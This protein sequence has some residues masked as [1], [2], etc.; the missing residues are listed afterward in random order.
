MKT[1]LDDRFAPI[2]SSIGYLRQDLDSA[3]DAL[4][5]WRRELFTVVESVQMMAALPECLPLLEPLTGGARPRELLVEVSGGW[6]AYFDCSLRGT[7]AVSTIGYLSERIGCQGLAVVTVPHTVH[8][9]GTGGQMGSVQFEMFG[10]LRTDFMNSVRSISASFD[11]NRWVFHA[12][13]TE[14]WFENSDAYKSRRIRDRF[15]AQMIDDYAKALEL[16]VFDPA[17]YGPR[18][19]LVS[20]NQ[21]VPPS[22]S[23]MSLE[24]V[25][26]WLGIVPGS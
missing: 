24:E 19:V 17:A 14:Q 25:Q 9:R 3:A 18:A 15:T 1:L 11:G 5:R 13:G 26:R 2:T 7:D 4:I 20:S 8:D 10:P 12:S 16:D 22:G 6:T 23:V 21:V